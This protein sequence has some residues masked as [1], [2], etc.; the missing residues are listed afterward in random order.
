MVPTM[1][2][3]AALLS[4]DCV[5]DPLNPSSFVTGQNKCNS[6]LEKNAS[7]TVRDYL[8]DL[9]PTDDRWTGAFCDPKK[10]A[11]APRRTTSGRAI[12]RCR[13]CAVGGR[14]SRRSAISSAPS[15][16]APGTT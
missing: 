6:P 13:R 5:A 16:P 1:A 8:A 14:A 9:N 2:Q 15:E 12:S 7:N 10:E 11:A 3:L 4:N